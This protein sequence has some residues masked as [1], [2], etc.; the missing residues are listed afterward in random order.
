ML[1]GV[2]AA[3]GPAPVL[4][5]ARV[6]AAHGQALVLVQA[7]A[8]AA[9]G[10]ALVPVQARARAAHGQAPAPVQARA[11][12]RARVR[13]QELGQGQARAPARGLHKDNCSSSW[14][15]RGRRLVQEDQGLAR[16]LGLAVPTLVQPPAPDWRGEQ[17]PHSYRTVDRVPE[18]CQRG[19]ALAL[20]QVPAL[21][22][23]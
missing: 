9:H 11:P 21:D 1:D 8:Q 14:I 5:P 10:Q 16:P 18:H 22:Q 15:Y 3:H 20:V 17:P 6:R 4:V 12:A 7:R 13:V 19:L 23:S 2:R